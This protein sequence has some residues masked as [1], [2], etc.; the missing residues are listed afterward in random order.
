MYNFPHQINDLVKLRRALGV[1]HTL[2]TEG[3]NPNDDEVTGIAMAVAGV[4]AFRDKTADLSELL[5]REAGKPRG[6]QGT[7]TFARDVRRFFL[8]TGLLIR[9]LDGGLELSEIGRHLLGLQPGSIAENLVWRTVLLNMALIGD[10]EHV[11]HPYKA[12]LRLVGARP[13]LDAARLALALEAK[14]DSEEEFQRVL[15]LADTTDWGGAIESLG[16]S[17]SMARNATKIL[18]ALARQLGDLEAEGGHY[19]IATAPRGHARRSGRD[20]A[21]GIAP[22]AHGRSRHQHRRVDVNSIA[23]EPKV[24]ARP[25]DED[26]FTDPAVTAERRHERLARHETLVRS[27]ATRM[28]EVG[29]EFLED[30]YDILGTRARTPSL[31]VEVKTLGGSDADE[32]AQ[33]RAALSQL[34]YYEDLD[35]PSDLREHGLARVAFLEHEPTE[36]HVAFL[37]S[38]GIVTVW[39]H[40]DGSF[41]GASWSIEQ[42]RERR[43]F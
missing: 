9:N 26:E 2:Q 14:D 16:I 35:V 5:R 6:S 3:S 4:Y 42:I 40:Q 19:R 43:L 31:L 23:R 38:H 30:P 41:S 10:S 13:G 22:S 12:L 27:M 15:E 8:L 25:P 21:T 7:Q 17:K 1:F 20:T 37:E 18:P 28:A 32:V 33:V 11:L 36:S 29:Y 24:G 39:L 34:L